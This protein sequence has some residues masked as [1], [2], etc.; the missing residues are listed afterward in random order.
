MF[1]CEVWSQRLGKWSWG[2][3]SGLGYGPRRVWS[4]GMVTEG[5]WSQEG[6]VP[7]E[8]TVYHSTDIQWEPPKWAVH[9]LLECI[10]VTVQIFN[11]SSFED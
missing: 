4:G 3:D 8:G 7:E 1:L 11:L 2:Y 5:V 9:I 6:M 10:L